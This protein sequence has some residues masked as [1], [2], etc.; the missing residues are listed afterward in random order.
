MLNFKKEKSAAEITGRKIGF[1]T[2]LLVFSS[3]LIC[4]LSKL[5]VISITFKQYLYIEGIILM[6]YAIYLLVNKK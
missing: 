3:L 1:L 5:K 2:A 4:V 6:I